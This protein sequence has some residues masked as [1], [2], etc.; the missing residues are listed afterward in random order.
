MSSSRHQ[1]PRP[2]ARAATAALLVAIATGFS[3]L[4]PPTVATGP[5]HLPLMTLA[6]PDARVDATVSGP[7]VGAPS[8]AKLEEIPLYPL[9]APRASALP[10]PGQITPPGPRGLLLAPAIQSPHVVEGLTSDGCAFCHRASTANKS[11]LTVATYRDQL[12]K[13]AAEAYLG[14]EFSLC[15][16]CHSE[17]PFIAAG[18]GVTGFELHALHLGGVDDPGSGGLDIGVPGD[19]QGNAICAECHFQLHSTLADVDRQLMNFA[20]NV[21]PR[22]GLLEW[23]GGGSPTCTLI[24]HGVSHRAAGYEP[25]AVQNASLG[26]DARISIVASGTELVGASHTFTLTVEL[27][28][29]TG[30]GWVAA[31]GVSASATEAG[32]GAIDL[33]ASTCDD[34]VTD[35]DGECLIV[36][37]SGVTGS[38]TVDATASVVVEGVVGPVNVG[39]STTGHGAFAISN[40]VTWADARIT[41]EPSGTSLLGVPYTFTVTVEQDAGS[42]WAP[43]IGIAVDPS[44]TDDGGITGGTCQNLSGDTDSSGQCTIVVDSSAVGV[45]TVDAAATVIVGGLPIA[46]STAGYG[47]HDIGNTVIWE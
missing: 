26:V 4:V 2:A 40:T 25:A 14:T 12:L 46:V 43:A 11:G 38:S 28:D 44:L 20:P 34:E 41:I 13:P 21:L 31:P 35:A 10:A 19:G 15:F 30:A 47:A 29:G 9:V 33:D 8:P 1:V 3:P 17:A 27:N 7:S 24:C 42:G 39:V 18:A 32:A 23:T 16:Q 45:S 22:G 6:K 37:D 36:V 5:S